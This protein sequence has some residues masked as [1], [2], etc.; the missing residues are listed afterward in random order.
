AAFLTYL[1]IPKSTCRCWL[2]LLLNGRNIM[3]I[4]AVI[5]TG[6]IIASTIRE[7]WTVVVDGF[8][9]CGEQAYDPA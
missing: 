6:H 7:C 3:Q 2:V 8:D 9:A 5:L 1:L 4:E